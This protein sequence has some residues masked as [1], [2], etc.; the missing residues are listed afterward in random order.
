MERQSKDYFSGQDQEDHMNQAILF[1]YSL[2]KKRI[3][4]NKA[5]RGKSNSQDIILN[6]KI[7]ISKI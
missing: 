1:F 6:V 7:I 3:F 2:H 5:K 4:H